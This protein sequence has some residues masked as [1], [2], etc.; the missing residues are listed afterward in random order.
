MIKWGNAVMGVVLMVFLLGISENANSGND[1]TQFKLKETPSL[2]LE[3]CLAIGIEENLG[4]KNER[5][6][7][8]QTEIREQ[9][10]RTS[11]IFPDIYMNLR[12]SEVLRP[13]K[14]PKLS[15]SMRAYSNFRLFNMSH[16]PMKKRFAADVM[17]RGYFNKTA[18]AN[19]QRNIAIAYIEANLVRKKQ[20]IMIAQ[21]LEMDSLLEVSASIAESRSPGDPIFRLNDNISPLKETV[22][23]RLIALET[24]YEDKI[25][26][27]NNLMSLESSHTFRLADELKLSDNGVV[28]ESEF[29]EKIIDWALLARTEDDE[30]RKM[31]LMEDMKLVNSAYYPSISAGVAYDEDFMTNFKGFTA[32]VVLAYNVLDPNA[33]KKKN[34]AKLDIEKINNTIIENRRDIERW[35]RGYYNKSK[36]FRG[37]VRLSLVEAQK[38]LYKNTLVHFF[39]SQNSSVSPRDVINTFRDYYEAQNNY[40][41]NIAN[42][43]IQIMRIRHLLMDF[44]TP[45]DKLGDMNIG[46]S[47]V[48]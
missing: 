4:L 47:Q 24:N 3:D 12:V 6:T 17:L 11:L 5:I 32:N 28:N 37:Q 39:S 34:L 1:S 30:I 2:S 9:I 7:Y 36:E 27:L 40:Y 8:R 42:S 29:V 44:E 43:E 46:L 45:F 19:L 21:L 38:D 26:Q 23:T 33:K 22:K 13:H 31:R 15:Q 25:G 18:N 10:Y 20:E 41:E 48:K 35:I 16:G 14:N